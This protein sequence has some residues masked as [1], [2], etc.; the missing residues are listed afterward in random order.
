MNMNLEV[1]AAVAGGQVGELVPQLGIG[2]RRPLSRVDVQDSSSCSVVG[3][4]KDELPVE[5]GQD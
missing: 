1:G 4:W 5:P 3:Q 2:G